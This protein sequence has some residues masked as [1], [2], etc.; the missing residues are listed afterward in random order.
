MTSDVDELTAALSRQARFTGQVCL[1]H[2]RAERER[3]AVYP[4]HILGEPT[5]DG[6]AWLPD[7]MR[8][9][10]AAFDGGR[11]FHAVYPH[12]EF[13]ELEMTGVSVFSL[14][15]V[16]THTRKFRARYDDNDWLR[17]LFVIG[18]NS[19]GDLFVADQNGDDSL[20]DCA[21]HFLDHEEFFVCT[22]GYSQPIAESVF[23]FVLEVA[24]N[25]LPYVAGWRH[26]DDE[27]EQYYVESVDFVDHR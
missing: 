4:T 6:D 2:L 26:F 16:A 14:A 23:A 5:S 13:G 7:S 19:S 20:G 9:L 25:P 15:E 11:L 17:T 10:A 21:V 22:P 12:P 18:C 1:P 8:E 3:I 27:G 24:T